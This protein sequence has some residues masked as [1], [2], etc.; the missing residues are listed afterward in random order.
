MSRKG[1]LCD[2]IN[3]HSVS[4]FRD[5]ETGAQ[6]YTVSIETDIRSGE[7]S[8]PIM[9]EEW[10]S[11][12]D[13]ELDRPFGPSETWYCQETGAVVY[14]AYRRQGRFHRDKGAAE[15]FYDR[16]TGDIIKQRFFSFGREL[17]GNSHDELR[18]D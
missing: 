5:H 7:F 12:A 4:A 17:P 3:Q 8:F 13:R 6:E 16:T 11:T 2:E 14:E 1:K 18:N 10:R 9:L 15:I